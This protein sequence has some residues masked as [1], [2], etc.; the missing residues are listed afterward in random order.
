MPLAPICIVSELPPPP[1]GMA[2]QAQLLTENL[3]KQGH[4]VFNAPTNPLSHS[5]SLR[6]IKWI[7]G[8]LNLS[9][10]LARLWSACGEADCVYIL[11]HSHLSFFLFTFPAVAVG[12]LRRKRIVI[13]Y[14]GGAAEPFLRSWFWLA[15]FALE[16]ADK[17]I[18]PSRF[19]ASVFQKFNIAT[20]E[21]PNILD[22][23]AFPFR[24]RSPL[25]PRVIMARHLEPAYNPACGIRAFAILKRTFPDATLIIAGEGSERAVLV[26]LCRDLGISDCVSFAGNVANEQMRALYD[27][28]D[29]YLNS[30][31]VDNQP[32]SI[33]EA[34]AC[35]L[36]VVTTA[37]GG[38]LCMVTHGED[39]LLAP[40]DDP[41]GLAAHMSELLR[42][43]ALGE[44]LIRNARE[45][46]REH[47]WENVYRTHTAIYL[48]EK[49]L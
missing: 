12:K 39:G 8:V 5:S 38:I 35:G 21:V 9:L 22:L 45:R 20:V 3:R 11:S 43:P 27:Q 46:V 30:S 34:F 32:V 49:H 13:H 6:R 10:F 18:V 24:E 2:V 7:R 40:D 42:D 19:L 16:S 36:P 44:R 33:L 4:A 26:S 23:E 41:A 1:G 47:S 31:R 14:H 25:R 48:P 15:R 28:A 29:I 17:V 37:V